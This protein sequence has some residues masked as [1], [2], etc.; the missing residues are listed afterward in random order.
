MLWFPLGVCA[1]LAVWLS[2]LFQLGPFERRDARWRL[3]AE[4][5]RDGDTGVLEV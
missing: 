4:G 2:F 3:A 1:G 5:K